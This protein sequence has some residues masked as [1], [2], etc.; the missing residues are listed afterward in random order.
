MTMESIIQYIN[1]L[2]N[3]QIITNKQNLSENEIILE[4]I[5]NLKT[6]NYKDY[7]CLL[8][9]LNYNNKEIITQILKI[10][11]SYLI[12]NSLKIK[13]NDDKIILS[14]IIEIDW[15]YLD[16]FPKQ[17]LKNYI[18]D[19]VNELQD[20]IIDKRY[21]NF[22]YMLRKNFQNNKDIILKLKEYVIKYIN[23]LQKIFMTDYHK[24]FLDI[25]LFLLNNN[26]KKIISQIL[27]I[28]S[29]YLNRIQFSLI[30]DD[31]K[32]ISKIL[33]IDSY[34]LDY[35]PDSI[36]KDYI[37]K[38]IN[39]L[40]EN[41][42]YDNYNNFKNSLLNKFKD[43][44]DIIFALKDYIIKYINE[45]KKECHYNY[46]DEFFYSLLS[47]FKDDKDIIFQA[48][49][50]DFRT[51]KLFLLSLINDRD[52]I[53]TTINNFNHEYQN[54]FC[55]DTDVIEY[56]FENISYN[57]KDDKEII[58][59]AIS[60]YKVLYNFASDRLKIDKDVI[61]YYLHEG[62]NQDMDYAIYEFL[63]NIKD[64]VKDIIKDDKD[65]ILSVL[66]INKKYIKLA[67]I[68]LINDEDIIFYMCNINKSNCDCDISNHEDNQDLSIDDDNK[69]IEYFIK[70]LNNEFLDDE[71][72]I[73]K[74]IKSNGLYIKYVSDRLKKNKNIVLEAIKYVYYE[75]IPDTFNHNKIRFLNTPEID[76]HNIIFV[77]PCI[78]TISN[79]IDI[80]LNETKIKI[81]NDILILIKQKLK[82]VDNNDEE[83]YFYNLLS[84]T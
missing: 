44:K 35:F 27:Q 26:D 52:I 46:N 33:E 70:N 82:H 28:Y 65:I 49:N 19:Y 25:L 20:N 71:N 81:D 13:N 84:K 3:I 8:F 5:N 60:C 32:I 30:D 45:L 53:L 17:L 39:D 42:K 38:Y 50:Y 24:N 54:E 64:N 47:R 43:D 78:Q 21:Y 51:I 75:Y 83:S 41:F 63:D 73:M 67:S 7:D 1:S 10:Y 12:V 48:V 15:D 61:L 56:L 34:Y 18:L 40:E 77:L 11:H 74:L 66:K 37:F 59:S 57:M 16:Q 76:F 23:E 4:Y 14:K 79:N 69:C 80:I 36:L 68:Q 72:I 2:K 6:F 9:L 29:S 22:K 58:L 62:V 55:I 31:K